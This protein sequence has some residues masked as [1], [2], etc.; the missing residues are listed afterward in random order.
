M[1][2]GGGSLNPEA[3]AL[4]HDGAR[5]VVPDR[6][7]YGDTPAPEVYEATSVPE[8]GEDLAG[9]L[10]ALGT[11]GPG[12]PILAGRDFGALACLDVL[13]RHPGL[14]RAAVLEDPPALSLVPEATEALSAER[15]A[16]EQAI[17]DGGPRQAMEAWLGEATEAPSRSFFADYAGLATLVLTRRELRAAARPVALVVTAR[18][19]PHVRLAAAELERTLPGARTAADLV[20][21]MRRVSGAA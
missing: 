4:A 12:L 15:I 11:S 13:L 5:V 16:L 19:Q 6:R 3:E 14:V 21:G 7:G 1:G 2:R 10:R 20:G 8:Q 9:L 18:A 17:R